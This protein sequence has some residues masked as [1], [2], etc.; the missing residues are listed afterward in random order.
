MWKKK[1]KDKSIKSSQFSNNGNNGEK[2]K[3]GDDWDSFKESQNNLYLDY[4]TDL[5][6]RVKIANG[7]FAIAL[8]GF[9][10]AVGWH[11]T[12]PITESVPYIL[13]VDQATGSVDMMTTVTDQKLTQNQAVDRYF[14]AEFVRN[15]EGYNY[16]TIQTT[17][18]RTLAMADIPVQNQYKKIYSGDYARHT[19]LGESGNIS[20]E[21]TSVI[22]DGSDQAPVARVRFKTT[23]MKSGQPTVNYYI[24]TVGYKYNVKSMSS[25]KRLLNPLGF[26]VASYTVSN[27]VAPQ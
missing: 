2:I 5:K 25:D 22:I 13:R 20:V 15:F 1:A 7:G 16:N 17:Y 11:L 6:K 14:V 23:T 21:I 3:K 4:T 26:T 18:D 8:I 12:N 19:I 9:F 10:G 24:S 27:E